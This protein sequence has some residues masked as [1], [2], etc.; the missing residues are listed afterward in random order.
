MKILPKKEFIKGV[1]EANL[2]AGLSEEEA[3]ERAFMVDAIHVVSTGDILV[4][5]GAPSGFR[6]HEVGHKTLGHTDR[7]SD[8]ETGSHTIGDD[9]WDEIL[10]EKYSYDIKGKKLTYRVVIPALNMLVGRYGWAPE[11]AVF[12]SLKILKDELGIIPSKSE[13]R[14]LARH[15]RGK[16]RRPRR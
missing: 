10:A 1:V 3:R 14:E 7:F 16:V 13:R 8:I 4:Q 9:I 15:V 2:E 11:T 5:K 12:W 6:L